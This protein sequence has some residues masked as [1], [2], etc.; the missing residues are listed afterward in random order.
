MDQNQLKKIKNIRKENFNIDKILRAIRF[1]FETDNEDYYEPVRIGNN[2][3]RIY[4][5]YESNGD[6]Y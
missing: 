3:S 2:F 6:E 4:I 1:L 5:E